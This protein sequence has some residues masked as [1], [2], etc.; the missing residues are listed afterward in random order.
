MYDFE[1]IEDDLEAN[2][3]DKYAIFTSNLSGTDVKILGVR[4]PIL[5]SLV[6]KYKDFDLSNYRL[7]G[8]Y[9]LMYLF[10]A[11][12]FLQ[13]KSF[14]ECI[15][16]IYNNS[17]FYSGWNLSDCVYKYMKIPKTFD[18][19]RTDIVDMLHNENEYI[20]RTGYLL[21]FNYQKEKSNLSSIF[22]LMANDDSYYVKMV[23]S[24]LLSSLY[25]FHQ[26]ET[27]MFLKETKIDKIIVNKTISKINDSFRVS[28][29]A[30]D[31]VKILRRK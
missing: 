21:C 5:R 25:I 6:K 20:R 22:S 3:D 29:E 2:I 12:S 27:F 23:E 9:E 18:E 11:I 16:I 15:E 19:A 14:K 31:L 4:L 26:E 8:E 10:F 30:K 17:D 13:S 1:N 24:W 7:K 28:K